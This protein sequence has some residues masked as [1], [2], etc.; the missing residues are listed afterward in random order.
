MRKE[1]AISQ[2]IAEYIN[3]QY[4]G[5]IYHFDTGSGGRTTIGMAMRNKKLNRVRGWPDLFIAEPRANF[6]GLFVEI[7]VINPLKKDGQLKADDHL[8]EQQAVITELLLRGY[9]AT[10]GVGFDGI[11]LIIDTYFKK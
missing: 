10:F 2:Q 11:K 9:W 5:I 1:D 8:E 3:L 7:K 4:P 6:K